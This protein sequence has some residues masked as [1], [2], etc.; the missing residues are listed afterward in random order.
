MS[1]VSTRIFQTDSFRLAAIYAGLF[2]VSTLLLMALV[3][4][5]VNRAFEA[6]L[7][8]ASGDDLLSIQ[9]AY[10]GGMPRGKALHE[11]TEMIEDRQLATD[12][13][14]VFL[15]VS[16]GRKIAGNLPL[17]P[18]QIGELRLP[19][20]A[21]PDARGIAGHMILGRGAF[22]GPGDYAFA[23]RDLQIARD[24][25]RDVIYAFAIVLVV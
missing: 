14:D 17:M 25:E 19:Y 3:F 5:A 2:L 20:P 18:A 15:L 9:R 8:R 21:A 1:F 23:G 10:A 12:S 13:S 7:L 11:A 22:L 4:F 6:D 24:A 16:R